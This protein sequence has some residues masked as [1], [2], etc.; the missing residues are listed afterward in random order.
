MSRQRIDRLG[1]RKRGQTA[2]G[3]GAAVKIVRTEFGDIRLGVSP[4]LAQLA[5]VL[6]G[7]SR[8]VKEV[9][10]VP[11]KHR[12]HRQINLRRGAGITLQR[13]FLAKTV[14]PFGLLWWERP[15]RQDRV[16]HR[17]KLAAIWSRGVGCFCFAKSICAACDCVFALKTLRLG[18][19]ACPFDKSPRNQPGI[20]GW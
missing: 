17:Q 9:S 11:I 15:S 7:L 10:E 19:V 16:D 4:S 12:S 6:E 3:Y 2:K 18:K 14:E 5:G 1:H 13:L 20:S 8:L